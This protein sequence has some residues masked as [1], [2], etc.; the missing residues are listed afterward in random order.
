[1]LLEPCSQAVLAAAAGLGWRDQSNQTSP[2]F[3]ACCRR[4]FRLPQVNK[5]LFLFPQGGPAKRRTVP[6]PDCPPLRGRLTSS[7]NGWILSTIIL[8]TVR[9]VVERWAIPSGWGR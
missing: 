9:F 2:K 7:L 5:F 3:P 6:R 4:P 8:H 1:M